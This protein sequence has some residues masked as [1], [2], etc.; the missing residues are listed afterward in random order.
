MSKLIVAHRGGKEFAPENSLEAIEKATEI[1]APWFE[2]DLRKTKDGK[3]IAWH[4]PHNHTY[5]ELNDAT[6]FKVPL[7]EDVLKLA[8]GKIKVDLE[9]KEHGY[10]EE[11]I[12]TVKKYLKYDEIIIT[13]FKSKVL[14]EIK[15]ID[16]KYKIGLIIGSRNKWKEFKDLFVIF[17]IWLLKA[18]ILVINYNYLKYRFF[19][20]IP[21]PI[22]VWTVNNEKII[23]K[24]IH[25]KRIT[26]II[27]DKP[28]KALELLSISGSF[29]K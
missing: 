8:K 24:F 2:F 9:I 5:D 19:F 12:K 20:W 25:D 13:S 16:P 3:L 11:T 6:D 27:T 18:D 21:V 10:V 17:R 29:R 1:G 22:W 15:R 28:K 4:D 23:S 26:A 7:L 14:R